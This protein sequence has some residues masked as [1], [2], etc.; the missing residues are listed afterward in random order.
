[1]IILI[2]KKKKPINSYQLGGERRG[3]NTMCVTLK[4]PGTS[5]LHSQHLCRDLL[6]LFFFS[7]CYKGHIVTINWPDL[8]DTRW[9]YDNCIFSAL[10]APA[11]SSFSLVPTILR[12]GPSLWGDIWRKVMGKKIYWNYLIRLEEK[13]IDPR[14]LIPPPPFPEPFCP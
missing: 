13:K 11:P 6:I 5:K 7:K 12:V 8:Y 2:K 4:F 10:P 1:M 3:R 14:Y 9:F